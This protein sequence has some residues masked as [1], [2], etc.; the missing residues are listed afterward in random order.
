MPSSLQDLQGWVSDSNCE[1]RDPLEHGDVASIVKLG[2]L[3]SQGA[4]LT[5]MSGDMM[6]GKSMHPR[7]VH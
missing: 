5:S 4:G 6:D 1:L 3:L 7:C 2:I